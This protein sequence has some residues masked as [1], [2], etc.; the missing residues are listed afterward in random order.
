MLRQQRCH[1]QQ[2][3]NFLLLIYLGFLANCL[4]LQQFAIKYLPKLE[5]DLGKL[6]TE[7]GRYVLTFKVGAGRCQYFAW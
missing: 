1:Y 7:T 3:G 6:K 2:L 5:A 4:N